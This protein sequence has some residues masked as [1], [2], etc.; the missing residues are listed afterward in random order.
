MDT[1]WIL[2]YVKILA[3]YI[4]LMF[5]WPSVVFGEYLKGK[6]KRDYF[7]FCVTV[8]IVIINTVVLMMGLFGLLNT[9]LV[10]VIF[11]GIFLAA[12]LKKRWPQRLLAGNYKIKLDKLPKVTGETVLLMA[13]W[14]FVVTVLCCIYRVFISWFF[15]CQHICFYMILDIE[16][17]HS[18]YR[19]SLALPMEFGLPTQFLCGAYLVRYMKNTEPVQGKGTDLFLFMMALATSIVS[20]YYTTIMAFIICASFA[21]IYIRKLLRP[22]CLLPLAVSVF[23]AA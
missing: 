20:H 18:M 22:A 13:Y 23:W 19:L 3:G 21:L 10:A 16:G 5:I 14:E 6:S 15:S 4:F 8:Q 2:E 7:S 1:Y 9:G 12:V 17:G 11:Y